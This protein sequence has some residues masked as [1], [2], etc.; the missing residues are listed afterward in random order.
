MK[1]KFHAAA[2]NDLDRPRNRPALVT[3]DTPR[4]T[5][6]RSGSAIVTV[7]IV[8]LVAMAA[9]GSLFAMSSAMPRRAK[10]MTDTIRAKA[11]AEA[12]INRAYSLL[13]DGYAA[14]I[15]FFPI[16]ATFADGRYDVT[17]ETLSGNES[18]VVSVGRFGS[19]VARVGADVRNASDSNSGGEGVPTTPYEQAIFANGN[20]NINGSP[21]EVTGAMHT[22]NDF[23]LSGN[24]DGVHGIIYAR[25]SEVIPQAYRG[26]WQEIPFPKLTD[27]D[28]AAFLAD[29]QARGILRVF[30]GNT[31]FQRDV[32]Y[33][34]V[35]V[36]N[37]NLTHG[38]SGTR[39]V[40]GMLYVTGNV[41]FNGSAAIIVRG[42]MIVGGNIRFNGSSI[43]NCEFEYDP[44]Y[45]PFEA[46]TPEDY[47][48][49]DAWWE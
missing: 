32:A 4:P 9:A 37:G 27:P 48:V 29:A 39:T 24:Y 5:R 12:G 33:T 46:E 36:V 34:G 44:T 18:R 10:R 6:K 43:S 26:N 8:I 40:N 16:G 28:F 20:L 17:I 45:L 30:N 49:I 13:R 23:S 21:K 14:G 35:V 22:N 15:A 42:A 47:V 1:M 3:P 11:I 25:N 2:A 41:E 19:A 38:G 7:M 31:T